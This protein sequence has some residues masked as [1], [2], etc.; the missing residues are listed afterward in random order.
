MLLDPAVWDGDAAVSLGIKEAA[1]A[2]TP[3]KTP[4]TI[5]NNIQKD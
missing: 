2:N 5:K 4:S 1:A 3:E